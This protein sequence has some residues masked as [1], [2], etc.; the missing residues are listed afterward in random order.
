VVLPS[1]HSVAHAVA[2]AHAKLP[3]QGPLVV[4]G[5]QVPLPLHLPVGVNVEPLQAELTQVV[6]CTCR[7]QPPAPSQVPSSPQA[8]ALSIAHSLSGS[9]ASLT[10]LQS[11]LVFPVFAFEHAMHSA[12]QAF[13]QQ[14]PSTHEPDE[15]S[16]SRPHGLP[17]GFFGAQSPCPSQVPGQSVLSESS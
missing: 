8:L 6:P 12:E 13:S 15:H 3:G 4:A 7:R 1:V 5:M 17:F 11:P 2:D 14:T 10:G 9:V 16:W